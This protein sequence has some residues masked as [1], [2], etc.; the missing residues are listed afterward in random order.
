VDAVEG[1]RLELVALQ[2]AVVGVEELD[3]DSVGRHAVVRDHQHRPLN[4][5]MRDTDLG[6]SPNPP[7]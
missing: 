2:L 5:S 7:S 3:A 4:G 1:I 6:V